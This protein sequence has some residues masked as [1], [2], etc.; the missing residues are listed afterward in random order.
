VYDFFVQTPR[1]KRP[2]G[3]LDFYP[4]VADFGTAQQEFHIGLGAMATPGTVRGLF[5]VHRELGSLPMREIVAPAVAA[6]RDGV[7]LNQLHAYI[8][9]IVAPIYLATAEARRIYASAVDPDR[10]HGEGETMRQPELADT[11]ERLA[12]EGDRLFYEGEMGAALAAL[13]RAHGGQLERADL[14]GFRTLRHA[15]LERR[16]R[17]A[18]LHL[19]PPPSAGGQLIAFALAL[20]EPHDLAGLGFGSPEHL[21]L[22]A[23][24]MEQ[25]NL[26]RADAPAGRDLLHEQ[27]LERFRA[28]LAGRPLASRGT[29]QISVVDAAGNAASLT[30]SNGEGCGRL[31]PGTGIML[32]N[33]LGEEDLN[34]QGFHAWPEN[35]RVSSMMAPTVVEHAG[36]L[37]ALGSGGSNRLRTAIL[38]TL[39]NLI[40]FGMPAAEAVAA[41]RVHLERG[42]VSSEPGYPAAAQEALSGI[43]PDHHRWDGHNL[44]FGGCHTVVRDGRGFDGAGDPRRGGVFRVVR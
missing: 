21:T 24:V 38:Q 15:P 34:P 22:L 8:F 27:W 28:N 41:P 25:T 6:A 44:F 12:A 10:L 20:L 36:R 23:R 4:I 13:S 32:N 37:V 3:E 42:R 29:T 9:N 1:R 2:L 14:A 31:L 40:D 43:W 33:M 39:S 11:L 16:Y 30:L 5:D 35:T 26:A 19:N 18:R 7:A 17:G